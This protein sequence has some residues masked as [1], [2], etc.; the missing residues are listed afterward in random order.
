MQCH[1]SGKRLGWV[2]GDKELWGTAQRK[3]KVN[4]WYP[5]QSAYV[6]AF[7]FLFFIGAI[8]LNFEVAFLA[9]A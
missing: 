2:R 5:I 9:L 3:T 7:S 8:S 1:K 6:K 4:L